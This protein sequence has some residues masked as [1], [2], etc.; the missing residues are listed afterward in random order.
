[1]L[2]DGRVIFVHLAPVSLRN[3][4]LGTVSIFQDVTHQVEVDRLKSE[5]VAT[6]SHELRTPMTSIKGYV[7][8]L[9]MG[10]A[11][12]LAPQQKHFLEVVKTNAERLSILVNDLLDI[13]QIESGRLTMTMHATNLEELTETAIEELKRR[14]TGDSKAVVIEKDFQ[15]GLPRVLADPDR[16]RRVL[17]NLLDNAYQYNL[18]NGLIRVRMTSNDGMVQVDVKDSGVGIHPQ[19]QERV[20]ERFFRGDST[21]TLGVAGTGLG[22]SI[23]QNLISMHKGRIWLESSGIPGEGSTFS[24]TLPVYVPGAE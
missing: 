6:V 4:F 3:D 1:M 21:L 18:P 9:L 7:D 8:I 17:D 12:E 24:F 5:F 10:A 13:S 23:V 20:F 22:L 16:I 19:D 11:G 14:T 2:E 15:P